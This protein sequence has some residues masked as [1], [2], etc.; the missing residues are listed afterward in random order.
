[1]RRLC[2]LLAALLPLAALACWLVP[3]FY[4]QPFRAQTPAGLD[5]ALSLREAAPWIASLLAVATFALAALLWRGVAR[6][7]RRIP[8]VLAGLAAAGAVLLGRWNHFETMFG[9][10][11]APQYASAA[12]ASF[13]ADDDIVL[14]VA[15]GDE[16]V[17]YPVRQMA[18]HHVV[19]DVVGG[20]PIL[21]TY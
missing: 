9:P 16:S 19:Q 7:W 17:A 11:R 21:A 8:L 3:A 2:G 13:V 5:R 14:S 10:L 20:V 4:V 12:D 18:Y 15:Q 1:M 6:P